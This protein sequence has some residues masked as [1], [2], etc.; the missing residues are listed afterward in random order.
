LFQSPE[1]KRRVSIPVAHS[2]GSDGRSFQL[3]AEVPAADA[4]A[5]VPGAVDALIVHDDG[6][7]NAHHR[8]RIGDIDPAANQVLA[9]TYGHDQVIAAVLVMDVHA[10]AGGRDLDWFG[11]AC[12]VAVGTALPAARPVALE[13]ALLAVRGVVDPLLG[14]GVLVIAL[15]L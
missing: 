2:R 12:P 11:V 13:F 10:I 9:L 8:V 5:I 3:A 4:R 6:R 14:I 15:Q 7:E 1:R